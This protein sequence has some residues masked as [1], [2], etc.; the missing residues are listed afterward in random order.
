MLY[1]KEEKSE[2]EIYEVWLERGI[3]IQDSFDWLNR[4]VEYRSGLNPHFLDHKYSDRDQ[5]RRSHH[6]WGFSAQ[7]LPG[8]GIATLVYFFKSG[9]DALRF[10]LTWGS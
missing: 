8:T 3:C 6:R 1:L 2:T 10:K 5:F 9:S 4:N 7:I